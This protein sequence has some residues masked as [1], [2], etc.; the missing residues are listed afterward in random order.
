[1]TSAAC[2]DLPHFLRISIAFPSSTLRALESSS[3]T[4]ALASAMKLD[5]LHALRYMRLSFT[6]RASA[7]RLQ[8]D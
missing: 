7:L 2:L 3:L 6:P 5:Q 1:M 4:T 8:F